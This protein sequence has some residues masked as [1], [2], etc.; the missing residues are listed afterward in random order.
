[1]S[2][3][4][5][6]RDVPRAESWKLPTPLTLRLREL[7]CQLARCCSACGG[8]L[9]PI[10]E[11][12]IDRSFLA[13]LLP[14]ACNQATQGADSCCVERLVLSNTRPVQLVIGRLIGNWRQLLSNLRLS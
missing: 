5:G 3:A 2:M 1:M 6:A 4:E 14:H 13:R 12:L 11:S 7:A 10:P 8:S 9:R